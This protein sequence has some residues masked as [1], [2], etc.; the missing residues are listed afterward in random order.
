MTP[1][2]IQLPMYC[3]QLQEIQSG[4]VMTNSMR[5]FGMIS[6]SIWQSV[7]FCELKA[8]DARLAY[9]WLHT[10]AKTCAGALRI[11]PAHLLEEVD[12]VE[13][14]ERANEIFAELQKA[15]LIAW[16]RPYVVIAKYLSFNPVK[17]YRHAIGAFKEALSLPDGE[18]KSNLMHELQRHEGAKELARW[19]NKSGDPHD[20][21]FSIHHFLE[22]HD[23]N[24]SEPPSDPIRI[25]SGKM[26]TENE[27]EKGE[28]RTG[29]DTSGAACFGPTSE[30]VTLDQPRNGM[31]ESVAPKPGP[32][33]ETLRTALARG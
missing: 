20:V 15:E 30:P 29:P 19:R 5:P 27:K 21:M 1:Q 13:T 16:N 2:I 9:L 32:R 3:G 14:L 4:D 10:S 33:P 6:T 17:T 31:N 8:N 28:L 26:R 25:P 11:G 18:M 24:P 22:V 23:A 7:R 12:F